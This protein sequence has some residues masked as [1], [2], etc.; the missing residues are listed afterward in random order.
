MN[1]TVSILIVGGVIAAAGGTVLVAAD[2]KAP[3]SSQAKPA[4]AASRP[5]AQKPDASEQKS[6]AP[7]KAAFRSPPDSAIPNNE[8]GEAVKLGAAIFRDPSAHAGQYVGNTL[9]CS[10]CHLD[11][12]RLANS[13]PM[14][15]AYVEYPAYRAKNGHVNTFEER[16]QGC[17]RFSMNG[18][19]PPLGDKVLVA[20][21]SYAYFLAKGAPTG[22]KLPGQGYLKL[23]KPAQT[24]DFAR[25]GEVFKAKCAICHGADGQGQKAE[26]QTI[27]PALWGKDSFNWGAG[28]GSLKNA[29]GF[30]KA[31]MPLGQGN[32]LTDQEAWD[33]AMFM[34]SHERPQDPRFTVDVATTRK[35][36]HDSAESMYGKEVDGILL[37]QNS[38]PSGP[39]PKSDAAPAKA[40]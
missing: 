38:P 39:Q 9:S 17:F 37:G 20:L 19:A 4:A 33:V 5:A 8:F 2:E 25:G 10:N 14:G 36:F 32:S 24:A 27:F 1:T 6:V 15:P 23:K 3:G 18:K 34:D 16:L 22:E 29:S 26:G 13:A 12:G 30:I 11:G 31:N 35:K 7:A 28:M 21:E 40:P